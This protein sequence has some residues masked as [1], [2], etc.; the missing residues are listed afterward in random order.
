M[1]PRIAMIAPITHPY[2][3]PSYGPWERVTHDLTEQLVALGHD[4][5]LF[6]PRGSATTSHL[7]ET[8]DDPLA[9]SDRHPRLEEEKHLAIAMEAVTDGG[10]DVVHSHL[11]VHAL[12]F[13]RMLPIPMLT[14]LHGSAW[15]RAHHDLLHRYAEM[16]FVS[17]SYVERALLP[18]LNY[19][20]TISNGIRV[21]EIPVGDG[22][23][24]YLAFA[25]RF[26][27]EKGPDLAIEVARA[28]GLPLRI[29][30]PVDDQHR[31]FFDEVL[32]GAPPEVQYVGELERDELWALL[33]GA[34]ALIMPLRWPEP[35]GLAVAESLAAGTPVI[36]WRMGA[37]PELIQ[38]GV[39][40]RLVDSTEDAVRAVGEI[41]QLSR[42][43]CRQSA[44]N[45]FSD[46]VMARF[47]SAVYS[48][49]L[50]QT[51][52][53]KSW[54]TGTVATRIP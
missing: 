24:G 52:S 12:V 34:S 30:G 32:G 45:R 7:V 38:D 33:G 18:E 42:S 23:G 9:T 54:A 31:E 1:K 35:F 5:T 28:A 26:A 43:M 21:E 15:D 44:E 48:G 53:S 37:M 22:T 25:G 4:V 41:D 39:T 19:V 50:S 10:F 16:P 51:I 2:P 13:S 8:V 49:L 29:A 27:P 3:P 17:I 14:T 20:A 6:A 47:Y 11:H 36:A 40:G 46:R